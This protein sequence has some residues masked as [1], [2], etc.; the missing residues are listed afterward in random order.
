MDY[1]KGVIGFALYMEYRMAGQT[2]QI[3]FTP[4]FLDEKTSKVVEPWVLSR[5]V[6]AERPKSEWA[7]KAVSLPGVEP[8]MAN[9]TLRQAP[10]V[11][12]AAEMV[13]KTLEWLGR[14]MVNAANVGWKFQGDP[15]IVE[16]TER[17]A[18]D[19][20]KNANPKGL[21]RRIELPSRGTR[22]EAGY[23]DRIWE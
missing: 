5:V 19:L 10:T 7:Y 12:K 3:L 22:V 21:L 11:S 16:V 14:Y 8:D 6:S 17:D 18:A 1:N 23:P 2:Q 4:P 20:S 13:D 9:K 15:I